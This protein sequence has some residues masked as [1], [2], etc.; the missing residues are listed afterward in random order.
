MKKQT[1]IGILFGLAI[2]FLFFIF[3]FHFSKINEG[4]D[5]NEDDTNEEDTNKEDTN[6]ED[7]NEEDTNEEDTNEE[8]TNEEDTNEEDTNEE[9]TNEE[10]T[11]EEEI[12]KR[13]TSEQDYTNTLDLYTYLLKNPLNLAPHQLGYVMA[14]IENENS[15]LFDYQRSVADD[16]FSY[17]NPFVEKP[18][19]QQ[20]YNFEPIT[21]NL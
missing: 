8:D 9:D 20:M 4:L 6:E 2:L 19:Y 15:E 3:I 1:I 13:N 5:T 11:N 7:T 16:Y 14:T 17:W 12:R 10:D 18:F 21:Y